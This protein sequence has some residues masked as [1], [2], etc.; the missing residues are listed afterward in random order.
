M[1]IFPIGT[2][3]PLKHKPWVNYVLI[4]LN[5]LV[6]LYTGGSVTMAEPEARF[7]LWPV[8]PAWYQFFTYQ[9][10]HQGWQHI[11]FNMLFLW[12]FGSNLEDRFGP[13][14]FLG[15]YL[16]G[17]V[18]AG[19]G[20]AL[21]Q[22]APVLGASGAVAAVTGAYLALFPR[23]QVTLVLWIFI[24]V[25]FFAVSSMW[26]ILFYFGRD[27][28]FQLLGL[29]GV[30]YLAH[31]SG[32]VFGFTVGMGL[33][34]TRILPREAYD[35]LAL[36]DRWHRRGQLRAATRQSGSPWAGAGG[37]DVPQS[38]AAGPTSPEQQ[39]IM[40][41]RAVVIESLRHERADEA[42]RQYRELAE[43]DQDRALPR[44]SQLDLANYAMSAQDYRT[45][46]DAYERFLANYSVDEYR[47]QVQLILGLIYGRYLDEPARA[48]ERL[49]EA[50]PRLSSEREQQLAEQLL[51][52]LGG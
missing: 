47:P 51:N 48:R 3:R 43:L 41:L 31:I 1:I 33:L 27:L 19:V 16:A 36:V 39:R 17:G 4:G 40:D 12:V 34:A 38:V 8:E 2:D 22:S 49:N 6:F 20:H 45:A 25:D 23:S 5:V 18:V 42:L 50:R 35:F 10:L 13:V 15:F 32:S 52:E 9:F 11:V 21:S 29:G 28:I 24:L 14:G 46:A 30:A 44:Q 7:M 26:L 37:G